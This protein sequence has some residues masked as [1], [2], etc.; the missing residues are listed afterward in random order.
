MVSPD[1]FRKMALALAAAEESPHFEKASF[2]IRRKIFATLSEKENRVMLRLSP[3]DQSVYCLYA[4]CFSPVP[5]TWGK[6]GA[7][8]VAL[9]GVKKDVLHE[10]LQ[11]AYTFVA[12][13]KK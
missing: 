10:A 8:F 1:T 3:A 4:P 7:T 9:E 11:A 12:S 6:S 5:G 2:R 13:P